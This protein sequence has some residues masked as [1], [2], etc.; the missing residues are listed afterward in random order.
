MDCLPYLKT[1]GSL[2]AT[3]IQGEVPRASRVKKNETDENKN[4]SLALN[5]YMDPTSLDRLTREVT[6]LRRATTENTR[7]TH[8]MIGVSRE[9]TRVIKEYNTVLMQHLAK[10]S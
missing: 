1:E 3:N 4:G 8:E 6:E 7:V 10:N 9:S 5:A 2:L